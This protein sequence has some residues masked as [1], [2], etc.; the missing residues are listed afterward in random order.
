MEKSLVSIKLMLSTPIIQ[1]LF[2]DI[3]PA[4]GKNYKNWE[5]STANLLTTKREEE[6]SKAL[7]ADQ[8]EVLGCGSGMTGLHW[9]EIYLD[10][11]I[12]PKTVTT[13][14]QMEKS[15]VWWGYCQSILEVT[16][17]ITVIGTNYH[18]NDLYSKITRERQIAKEHIYKRP[19]KENGKI[20]YSSW[21]REK[22]YEK[23]RKRQ[24]NYIWSCQYELNPNPKE[25]QIFPPPQPVYTQL[26]ADEYSYYI[27]IDPA[28]T[29]EAYSDETG[30]VIA[31]VNKINQVWVVEALGF[32]KK[33]NEIADILIQKCLQYKPV[34]VGIEFGLQEHLRY[35][36]ESRKASWEAV[37]KETV[38]LNIFSVPIS[39]KMSKGARINWTLGAFVRE[40]KLYINERCTDLLHEMDHFTGKGNEKDNLVDATSMIF[41]IVENFAFQYWAEPQNFQ[42]GMT[43]L[44]LY[45]DDDSY[46][47]RKEF[48]S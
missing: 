37:H 28:A 17:T 4:P 9:D 18:Y 47:W 19:Y 41:S 36:I 45:K 30:M 5:R 14:E 16:G 3:V 46:E 10:D 39:R 33:G 38:P 31:G 26:P 44:D 29:T 12:D 7:G 40:G 48:A 2:P 24:T 34:R 11:I 35:I 1:R 27:A 43:F 13:A 20:L 6:D 8:V 42:T 32:K 25:D 15:E 23:I 22:D 21:F